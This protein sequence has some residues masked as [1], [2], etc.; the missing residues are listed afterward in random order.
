M[1]YSKNI[2]NQNSIPL[3]FEE[4]EKEFSNIVST[5]KKTYKD[6]KLYEK[7]CQQWIV[8][9]NNLNDSNCFLVDMEYTHQGKRL[10]RFDLIA[11]S[12]KPFPNKKYKVYLI[13]LKVGT[14]SY[15][16]K[17]SDC[18]IIGHIR[19]YLKFFDSEDYYNQLKNNIYNILTCYKLFPFSNPNIPMIENPSDLDSTP[20]ILLVS[21][22]HCPN[23]IDNVNNK[24]VDI[25]NMKAKLKECL[26]NSSKDN[27]ISAIDDK[28]KIEGF[29]KIEESN[30]L[31]N[32]PIEV[33]QKVNN[34]KYNF[35]F[36][37]IDAD[38]KD[39]W[40]DII[41]DLH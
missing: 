18:G 39:C 7:I 11:I 36:S 19:D 24:K 14:K 25:L 10:G 31:N 21:Y 8:N 22:S 2:S 12:R 27:L 32:K 13:E 17:S 41:N 35:T 29:L 26:F 6:Q 30:F 5:A 33:T 38:E 23:I 4:I 15:G 34:K 1:P 37:F 28:K 3:T 20:N 16:K 9:N 40:K